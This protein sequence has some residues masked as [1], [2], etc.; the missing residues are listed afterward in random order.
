RS[1]SA[2]FAHEVRWA[3]TVRAV[4]PA[5]YAGS[6]ISHPL[7]LA[8][9]AAALTG[10]GYAGVTLIAAA[11]AS[12][13]VLQLSVDHTLRVRSDRWWLVPARDLLSFAVYAASYFVNVVD[14]AGRRYRVRPDGTLIANA[15]PNG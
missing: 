2:L 14:W 7:P 13:L 5:G 8:V 9:V 11:I 4:S 1:A 6:L 10:F 12:R 15:E 3:R